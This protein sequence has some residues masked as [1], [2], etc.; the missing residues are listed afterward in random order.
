MQSLVVIFII[1]AALRYPG[2]DPS[3]A[4]AISLFLAL[5]MWVVYRWGG[6]SSLAGAKEWFKLNPRF[7]FLIAAQLV[8]LA[9]FG[10]SLVGSISINR[11]LA[12]FIETFFFSYALFSALQ[13]F[14]SAGIASIASWFRK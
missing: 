1:H 11:L 3:A 4:T 6:W 8:M 7:A 13:A 10:I 9:I 2:D 5:F 14:W 12:Y